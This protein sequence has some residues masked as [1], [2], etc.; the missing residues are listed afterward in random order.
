MTVTA[1]ESGSKA[2]R[3]LGLQ[4]DDEMKVETAIVAAETH[5]VEILY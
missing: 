5:Q 4:E 2:L 1:V 3:F